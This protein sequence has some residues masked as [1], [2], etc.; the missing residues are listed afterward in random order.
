MTPTDRLAPLNAWLDALRAE[1]RRTHPDRI[2]PGFEPH[3]PG[4]TARVL[5]CFEKPGTGRGGSANTLVCSPD[6]TDPSGRNTLAFLEQAGI[7]RRE[8]LFWNIVPWSDGKRNATTAEVREGIGHLRHLLSLLPALDSIILSGNKAG[9][10]APRLAPVLAA[11]GVR[12]I[13]S[14][15]P[16][17]QVKNINPHLWNDIPRQWRHAARQPA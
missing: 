14:A 10:A 4:V 1:F 3:G 16:S 8:A 13:L 5:L 2:L 9:K 7:D 17:P 12:L 6:N 11:S 15:H